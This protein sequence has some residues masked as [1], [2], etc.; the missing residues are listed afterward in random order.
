MTTVLSYYN[1]DD[2]I[3]DHVLTEEGEDKGQP[4]YNTTFKPTEKYKDI[5]RSPRSMST[6]S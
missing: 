3:L 4:E 2:Y 1:K 5:P 6:V